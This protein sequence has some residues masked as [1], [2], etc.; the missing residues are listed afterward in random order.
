MLAQRIRTDDDE[1]RQKK[2]DQVAHFKEIWTMQKEMANKT[3]K[4]ENKF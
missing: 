2:Q 3:A 1:L 4:A